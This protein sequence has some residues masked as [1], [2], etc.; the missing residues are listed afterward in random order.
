[1]WDKQSKTKITAISL[2]ALMP[3][4]NGLALL[5]IA[6]KV[7]YELDAAFGIIY[8]LVASISVGLYRAWRAFPTTLLVSLWGVALLHYIICLVRIKKDREATFKLIEKFTGKRYGK[9]LEQVVRDRKLEF[10]PLKD[11][12]EK[13]P[14]SDNNVP[15]ILYDRKKIDEVPIIID[16]IEEKKEA[17]IIVEDGD[18][19]KIAPKTPY[20][21]YD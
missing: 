12:A 16:E 7:G 15:F 14:N 19:E 1:M 13:S 3:V 17:P 21:R 10:K 6:V 8:F 9:R 4:V 18:I 20:E 5:D 2:L 11:S